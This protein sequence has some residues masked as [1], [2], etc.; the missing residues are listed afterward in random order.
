MPFAKDEFVREMIIERK[1]PRDQAEEVREKIRKSIISLTVAEHWPKEE[2][3]DRQHSHA[4][5]VAFVQPKGADGRP[6]WNVQARIAIAVLLEFGGSGGRFS[7][8]V[9]RDVAE[10]I[11]NEFP[12]YVTGQHSLVMRNR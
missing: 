12:R 9:C 2:S 11:I 4:W 7:G 10:M 6:D 8:P 3:K 1:V 5:F